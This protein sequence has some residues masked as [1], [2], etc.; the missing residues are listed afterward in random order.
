MRKANL[1]WQLLPDLAY[2]CE[3][4][5]F[6]LKVDLFALIIQMRRIG[7]DTHLS[8]E[9]FCCLRDRYEVN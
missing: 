8:Y 7:L 9:F 4:V 1:H 5:C 3:H 6:L 2:P